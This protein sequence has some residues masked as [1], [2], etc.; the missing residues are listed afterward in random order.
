MNAYSIP[1]TLQ[2]LSDRFTL[3]GEVR[4][5]AS[6]RHQT[7]TAMLDWSHN[8]L[9]EPEQM[10]LRRLS[11]FVGSFT[12]DAAA[13]VAAVGTLNGP[14][15]VDTLASLVEK[16]MVSTS[17]SDA[18]PRYRLL[19]TT[20]AYAASKL[21]ANGEVNAISRRHANYFRGLLQGDMDLQVSP[22]LTSTKAYADQLDNLR[23]ALEWSFS[24]GGEIETGIALA[25]AGARIF[26]ELS[27]LTECR[28]WSEAALAALSENEQG[29][30][31][32]M[33]LQ[34]ALGQSLML[35]KGNSDTA[36]Q[37]L[38]KSLELAESVGDLR[39]QLRLLGRLIIFDH[40][41][42]DCSSAFGLARR[43]EIVATSI[44]DQAS[45]A[46]ANWSLGFSNYFAGDQRSADAN[47]AP[48]L[49]AASKLNPSVNRE[50]TTRMRCGLIAVRWLRGFPD[51]SA[52]I[53]RDTLEEGIS[54]KDPSALC[55]CLIFAG[56]A[57]LRMGHWSEAARTMERI[58]S[59]ATQHSLPPFEAIGLAMTGMLAIRRGEAQD[60]VEL[61]RDAVEALHAGQ[62]ELH[63][64]V[65]LGGLAEGLA[66]IGRFDE[67]LAT[68]DDAMARVAR[69]GQMFSLPEF[70]R[71]KGEI[72]ISAPK[73]DPS[74]AEELFL[75]SIELARAQSALSWE[76]RSATSLARLWDGK[77]RVADAMALLTPVYKRFTEG[78][79]TVDLQIAGRLLDGLRERT[80]AIRLTD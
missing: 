17:R 43:S 7:L 59:H 23:A 75:K 64:P 2:L 44:G 65:F 49:V 79:G 69:N 10:V 13:D 9:T 55:I 47:W 1:E 26:L 30:K 76:L 18:I 16:S 41:A 51:Q 50:T 4:R 5:T 33:E 19:D 63:N 12:L 42:G 56:F 24:E 32:E 46:E 22:Q 48:S 74:E 62:Y 57:F 37:A 27:L 11:V 54:F 28:R 60:G 36:R 40:R 20:R 67:A 45:I 78:F 14:K 6:P 52:K 53:A 25:T 73:E 15:V 58:V 71:I 31:R 3:L 80:L 35:A 8:L 34:A 61:I 39:S 70:M 66:T 38:S 77:N 21:V 72:L 29:T 68:V